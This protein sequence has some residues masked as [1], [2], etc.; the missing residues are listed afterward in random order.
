MKLLLHALVGADVHD[1]RMGGERLH[2]P[3]VVELADAA[4]RVVDEMSVAIDVARLLD[5]SG[6][7]AH[8]ADLRLAVQA[9]AREELLAGETAFR[10]I[11]HLAEKGRKRL[12]V[13]DGDVA[14]DVDGV[15]AKEGAQERHLHGRALDVVDDRLFE[16]PGADTVVPRVVEPVALRE[17]VR[18][19][20]LADPGHAEQR[21]CLVFPPQ[22]L[23]PSHLHGISRTPA[24]ACPADGRRE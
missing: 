19:R 10:R 3:G 15:A 13:V 12:Q 23:F 5:E 11:P 17:P 24:L 6:H 2:R 16:V 14:A 21:D 7:V 18:E 1:H 9:L 8:R 20:R 22:E 4:A